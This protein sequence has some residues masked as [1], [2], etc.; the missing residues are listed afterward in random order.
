VK[1]YAAPRPPP[2]PAG[3][4]DRLLRLLRFPVANVPPA[5]IEPANAPRRLFA[6]F[7]VQMLESPGRIRFELTGRENAVNFKCGIDPEAYEK[8][9]TDGVDFYVE[10][11]RPGLP[12][13]QLFRRLLRPATHPEDRGCQLERVAL[14]PSYP[15]CSLVL[16]TDAGPDH[17]SAWDWAW[18]SGIR[19]LQGS[20]LP[21]AFPNFSAVPVAADAATCGRLIIG[22]LDVFLLN[23]PGRLFFALPASARRLVFGG[24]LLPGAYTQGGNS[25]GADFIVEFQLP[26]GS[27]RPVFRRTLNP[28]DN[29][30]DRGTI[31]FEV[32]LPDRPAGTQLMVATGP[33]PSG[34]NAWDWTY[35]EHLNLE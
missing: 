27:I 30:A 16:R 35:L 22:N 6:A 15:G 4:S 18:F 26:D 32:P 9:R 34:S 11:L 7:L 20:Y 10:L 19:L 13:Q 21:E 3:E 1:F 14:P 23:A 17:D 24:G 29:P 28:R 12:P 31:N 2:L 25:D 33:G 8:G 5:S